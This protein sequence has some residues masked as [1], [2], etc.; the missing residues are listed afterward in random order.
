MPGSNGANPSDLTKSVLDS[1]VALSYDELLKRHLADYQPLFERSLLT[2]PGNADDAL[3]TIDRLRQC[4]KTGKLSPALVGLLYH[5]GRYLL[6][7]CS[8]PGT[9]AANLQGIWNRQLQPPWAC[10]YTTNINL[11]MNYWPAE[12]TNLSE[13]AEPIL[14]FA[15]DM[16]EK[17]AIGAKKVFG[18]TLQRRRHH[19]ELP[20]ERA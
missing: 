15:K 17:G 11:E 20:A 12:T 7:S 4:S 14:S 16:S 8:R 19:R 6:I 1:A 2:L 9:Q 10:N 3:P 18:A 13:L 5:F